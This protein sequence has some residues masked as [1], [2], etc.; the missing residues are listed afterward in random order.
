MRFEVSIFPDIFGE[1]ATVVMGGRYLE[2][3][4]GKE[5][6]NKRLSTGVCGGAQ[7]RPWR[8]QGG[9]WGAITQHGY[10]GISRHRGGPRP[11]GRQ[12]GRGAVSRGPRSGKEARGVADGEG[13]TT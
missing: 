6:S 13:R 2:E 12:T 11:S 5:R 10:E 8:G 7:S 9:P 3:D 4:S 1:G